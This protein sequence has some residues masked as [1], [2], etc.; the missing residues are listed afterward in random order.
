[1][2]KRSE[3]CPICGKAIVAAHAPFC[4]AACRDRDLIRW[5]DEDYRVPLKPEDD[6]DG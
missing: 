1:M 4:S 2:S 5:L 3:R 6:G